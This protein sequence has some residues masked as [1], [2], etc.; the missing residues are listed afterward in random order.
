MLYGEK[1]QTLV[2]SYDTQIKTKVQTENENIK[3]KAITESIIESNFRSVN[4]LVEWR[5]LTKRTFLNQIRSPLFMRA[6]I[7][8]TLFMAA[9][10]LCL[11]W[12]LKY[13]EEGIRGKIGLF[14][15][16][17]IN[18]VFSAMFGVLLSFLNERDLFLREYSNQTYGVLSYFFAKN[19]VE[20]PFLAIMPVI[21]SLIVY[22]G[23]G[24]TQEFGKFVVFCLIMILLVCC[25]SSL[26]LFVGSIFTNESVALSFAP[27]VISPI[28]IFSGVFVDADSQYVFLRWIQYISPI[29]YAS[30]A[31]MRN[32]FDGNNKYLFNPLTL[33]PSFNLGKWE[34]ILINGCL[35]VGFNMLSLLFLRLRIRKVQ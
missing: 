9:L 30:E 22:F 10:V 20:I 17:C 23:V 8:S 15:F 25:A 31:L 18:Q 19:V 29:R 11:F 32:E 24:L 33:Y 27:L 3:L 13:D 7:F 1:L 14:F 4:W 26:G 16:F 28:I 5:Y 35:A 12:K 6:R 21:F 2:N 34:C